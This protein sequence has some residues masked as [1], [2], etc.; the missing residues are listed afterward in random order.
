[1]NTQIMKSNT[2]RFLSLEVTEGLSVKVLPDHQH[3]ALMS[4]KEVAKGYGVSEDAIKQQ[5][6][7]HDEFIEGKH[8][9][10][11]VTFCHGAGIS[12]KE[13]GVPHNATLWSQRGIVRLG[14]FITSPR[15]RIF[16]DWIEDLAMDRLEVFHGIP[17][18]DNSGYIVYDYL[19]ARQKFGFSTRSGSVY[20]TRRKYNRHFVQLQRRWYCTDY[21]VLK[22]HHSREQ[23]NLNIKIQE[24][25]PMKLYYIPNTQLALFPEGG[26]V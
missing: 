26:L 17:K 12:L 16:R 20:A 2:T 19:S 5:K 11:A 15:A 4:T 10:V 1:M 22:M 8:H 9:L 13:L 6:S 7:R 3:V 25:Q 18:T 24:T 23:R 14:F 21:I